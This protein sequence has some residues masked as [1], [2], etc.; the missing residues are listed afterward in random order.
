MLCQIRKDF[1]EYDEKY[2]WRAL[3]LARQ[4]FGDTNPNPMVGSVIVAPDGRIIGEGWHRKC[5]EGHA[6][7]NAVA[8]VRPG[9]GEL[10]RRSTM[11]VTLEPCSHWGRTP[12][13]ARLIID[14][15][16]PRVVVGAT[17]P[18][19]KVSG[20]G[21][22]M[23]REA[24]VEVVTGVLGEES[25]RLNAMFMTANGPQRRPFVTLKFAQ[26]A[27]GFID[28]RRTPLHPAPCRF[29]T[30]Y[31]QLTG[32]RL[33]A[34]HQA[35]ICGSGTALAD[36]PRL[37]NRLWDGPRPLP[38]ILDRRGRLNNCDVPENA[39]IL[40][41][42]TSHAAVLAEL[43]GRGIQSVLVEGGS[44]VLRAFLDSGLWDAMRIE[45]A[46]FSLGAEGS[47]RA[48]RTD[49]AASPVKADGRIAWYSNN[50]LF[51]AGHP[52]C[53]DAE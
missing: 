1:M 30:P 32:H 15:A 14:R 8:S 29:S 12:P 6:E 52:L 18:F 37:D 27:D 44:Q 33:R 17:D 24:G 53:R 46:P 35:V 47:V 16:I 5:G 19:D 26:S 23:L 42:D 10:L 48:P 34:A 41:G 39:L 28:W 51:T 31:T 9:D 49:G 2:M 3:Q 36:R 4:G 21:I 7:V 43:Y 11:Y 45:T 40:N 25:R 20:R 38:V 50:Q 13:C 22:A